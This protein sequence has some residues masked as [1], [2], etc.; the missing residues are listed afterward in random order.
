MIKTIICVALAIFNLF[1]G[2]SKLV[3]SA[4]ANTPKNI[5][6]FAEGAAFS[7][8]PIIITTEKD[9]NGNTLVYIDN[10]IEDFDVDSATLEFKLNDSIKVKST[11][12]NQTDSFMVEANVVKNDVDNSSF[13]LKKGNL[14]I[15]YFSLEGSRTENVS[16]VVTINFEAA[17]GTVVEI[18]GYVTVVGHETAEGKPALIEVN[19]YVTL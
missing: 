10:N 4:P 6:K 17:E 1:F 8:E 15:A 14:Y 18:Y 11:K 7:G 2:T 12:K 16:P 3:E 5:V 9:K 19:G 13:P